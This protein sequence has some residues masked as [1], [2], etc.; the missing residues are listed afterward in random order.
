MSCYCCFQM[1]SCISTVLYVL[2]VSAAVFQSIVSFGFQLNIDGNRGD[3]PRTLGSVDFLFFHDLGQ[4]KL[5]QQ[6]IYNL[7]LFVDLT[8]R[9]TYGII[10]KTL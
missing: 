7:E 10:N 2:L 4:I 5:K 6:N 8:Y 9:Y 1:A 3:S